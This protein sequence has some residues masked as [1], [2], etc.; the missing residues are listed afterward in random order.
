ME[1]QEQTKD[2]GIDHTKTNVSQFS[3]VIKAIFANFKMQMCLAII[4][5]KT[6]HFVNYEAGTAQS[7]AQLLTAKCHCY[8]Y[9]KRTKE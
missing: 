7:F 3:L 8:T 5:V 1:K 6:M 2:N 4:L 9:A